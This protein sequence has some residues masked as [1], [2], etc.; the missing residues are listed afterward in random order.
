M[1]YG[2]QN[3][4]F[5]PGIE[6]GP[7]AVKMQSPNHSGSAVKK[8]ACNIG[9]AGSI[10]GVGRSPRGG[11][12]NPIQY[13]CLGKPHGQRSLA[14]YSPWGHKKLDTTQHG[15]LDCQG[16]PSERLF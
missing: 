6:P 8:S 9:D 10:P 7:L 3:L 11:N 14:G 5:P 1:P 2:L 16:I 13:S 4:S 12:G 15:L